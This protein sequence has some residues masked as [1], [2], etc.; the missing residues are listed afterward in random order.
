MT[1]G[2]SF[3]NRPRLVGIVLLLVTF[4]A[5]VFSGVALERRVGQRAAELEPQAKAQ[6]E[7]HVHGGRP[8]HH[9]H[10]IDQIDLTP[11]QRAKVDSILQVGR[12]R[13]DAFW[14]ETG[15]SY[16]ALVDST[17][18][19]VRAIMTP[20][21]RAQYDELRAAARRARAQARDEGAAGDSTSGEKASVD[22]RAEGGDQVKP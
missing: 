1:A 21:Q 15:P 11:E 14:K 8:H 2:A 20:E 4:A 9:R 6:P 19:Q 13:L 18:A 3:T 7:E 5:G 12:Q 16:R 17:R 10:I 22:G